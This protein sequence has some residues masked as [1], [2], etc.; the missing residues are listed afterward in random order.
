MSLVSK[1][2]DFFRNLFSSASLEND[3][4]QEVCSHLEMMIAENMRAGMP[5]NEAR[6]AALIGGLDIRLV[7]DAPRT[8]H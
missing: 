1:L 6:R 2:Q 7:H 3:L 5:P 4:D 8:L